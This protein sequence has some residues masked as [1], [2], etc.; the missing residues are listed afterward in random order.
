MMSQVMLLPLCVAH[1]AVE[2]ALLNAEIAQIVGLDAAAKKGWIDGFVI[3]WRHGR[4]PTSPTGIRV[5]SAEGRR[6][7]EQVLGSLE[8]HVRRFIKH[9]Q[10]GPYDPVHVINARRVG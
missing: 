4:Y 2:K 3:C 10:A 1:D 7:R 8:P 5:C 9:A 6:T